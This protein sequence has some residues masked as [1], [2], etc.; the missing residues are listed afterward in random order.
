MLLSSP[1]PK[2]WLHVLPYVPKKLFQLLLLPTRPSSMPLWPTQR[3]NVRAQSQG[4]GRLRQGVE[5]EVGIEVS[6]VG[7]GVLFW[8]LSWMLSWLQ[9]PHHRLL[10]ALP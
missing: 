4:P 1:S 7:V 6:G 9:S 10:S 5:V 8:T 3:R 2:A